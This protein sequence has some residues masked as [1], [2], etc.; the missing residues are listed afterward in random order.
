[1]SSTSADLVRAAMAERETRA[2]RQ[3]RRYQL[4]RARR[5]SARADRAAL[6]ARLARSR[7]G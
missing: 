6:R 5:L 1:M 4:V 7:I 3:R 2:R